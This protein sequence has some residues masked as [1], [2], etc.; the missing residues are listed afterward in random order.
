MKLV[1]QIMMLLLG[2]EEMMCLDGEIISTKEFFI[3]GK[4][5]SK[6]SLLILWGIKYVS[7]K[8]IKSEIGLCPL[9][10]SFILVSM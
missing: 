9:D 2:K 1:S 4:W 3:T 6:R 7:T 10:G 5:Y 8:V